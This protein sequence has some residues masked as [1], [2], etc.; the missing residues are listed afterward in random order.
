MKIMKCRILISTCTTGY[1]IL[2]CQQFALEALQLVGYS[3]PQ[4]WVTYGDIITLDGLKKRV[5]CV[6]ALFVCVCMWEYMNIQGFLNNASLKQSGKDLMECPTLVT[7][8]FLQEKWVSN[9]TCIIQTKYVIYLK[10][11]WVLQSKGT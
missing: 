3:V 5:I 2:Y 4:W 1:E 10:N 8:I 7:M 11:E 9:K 6:V